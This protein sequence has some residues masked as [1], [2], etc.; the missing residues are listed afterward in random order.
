M[1]GLPV[2]DDT[3]RGRIQTAIESQDVVLFM[4]GDRSQPQCGFSATVIQILNDMVPDYGTF[5]VLAD[6]E[7]RNGIKEFSS[8]PTIPQ[9]YVK[10]EFVGGCDIIQEMYGSGELYEAFGLPVPERVPPTLHL[11][12]RAVSYV[13]D[14]LG[15]AEGQKLHL[16]IGANFEPRLY[17]GPEEPGELEA[18]AGGLTW[19][20]DLPSSTRANGIRID[21]VETPQ[22]HELRVDNPNAP[23][24]VKDIGVRELKALLDSDEAVH[25]FDV[26]SPE[27]RATAQIAGARLLDEQ[28]AREIEAMPKETRLIFHCHH[29][30]RS[31]KAAEHFLSL[32]FEQVYNVVG[33]IDA[34]SR[35]VDSTVP[36]Y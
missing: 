20:V 24:A 16:R 15:Q 21:Y 8:W 31:L 27:E 3:T 29:G 4:K 6:P 33:G 28:R 7:V 36:R 14:A 11:T 9:L 30:G 17:L 2:L 22:G 25:L 1:K 23:A 12:D 13:R 26:R 35:Q 19:Y 5:D 10:G 32:G 34:W 18:E